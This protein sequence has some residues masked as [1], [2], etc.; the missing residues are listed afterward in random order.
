M[1]YLSCRV[2][3]NYEIMSVLTFLFVLGV[4]GSCRNEFILM[5][6]LLIRMSFVSPV[7]PDWPGPEAPQTPW[8]RCWR[9]APSWSPEGSWGWHPVCTTSYLQGAGERVRGRG[10]YFN[11]F[12][13]SW[14]RNVLIWSYLLLSSTAK[15]DVRPTESCRRVCRRG[16]GMWYQHSPVGGEKRGGGRRYFV[17][18]VRAVFVTFPFIFVFALSRADLP[19][20]VERRTLGR[21]PP[22]PWRWPTPGWLR[23]WRWTWRAGRCPRGARSLPA[24]HRESQDLTASV[25]KLFNISTLFLLTLIS[26]LWLYSRNFHCNHE[27]LN[28]FSKFHNLI[29]RISTLITKILI[30]K[31]LL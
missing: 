27:I 4:R 13:T 26:K 17:R 14:R 8:W 5:L 11:I 28:F 12:F 23:R 2:Q 1:S 24:T 10:K 16:D 18:Q 25:S 7:F 3:L 9:W 22:H 15:T 30:S 29:L 20:S 31:F 19:G 21:T 6:L